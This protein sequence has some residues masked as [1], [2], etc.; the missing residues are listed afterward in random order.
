MMGLTDQQV[1]DN[2][3][4]TATTLYDWL[5]KYPEISE[6]HKKG[7]EV[8]DITVMNALYQSAIDGNVTAMIFWMKNRMGWK[9][10]PED[11]ESVKNNVTIT[12]GS[13]EMEE[14]GD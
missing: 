10:K 8:A 1:A 5:N 7:R 2:M 12:F 6:D 14:Y 11:K 4:I 9:D 3:G 13:Q